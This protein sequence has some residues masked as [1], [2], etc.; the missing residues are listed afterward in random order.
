M[1][2]NYLMIDQQKMIDLINNLGGFRD[3]IALIMSLF[4]FYF[5]YK[6]CNIEIT[7]KTKNK[8]MDYLEAQEFSLTKEW[9][10]STCSQGE[11]CWC[12]IIEPIEEI[13]DNEENQIFIA[14]SGSISELYAE[15]IVKLHNESLKK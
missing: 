15:H 14:S 2:L 3:F 7:Y 4:F 5:I 9:K 8:N 6:L 10:I 13:F 1:I 12:R 11:D